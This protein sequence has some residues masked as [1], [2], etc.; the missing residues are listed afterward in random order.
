[1][2][3]VT[4]VIFAL[5]VMVMAVTGCTLSADREIEEG[6]VQ[7]KI[8]ALQD[9]LEEMGYVAID[10]GATFI[11]RGLF[12]VCEGYGFDDVQGVDSSSRYFRSLSIGIKP[13]GSFAVIPSQ[14]KKSSM[15]EPRVVL[16]V[17]YSVNV[18]IPYGGYYDFWTRED[19]DY[20][21]NQKAAVIV[22]D[23]GKNRSVTCWVI[24]SAHVTELGDILAKIREGMYYESFW[25]S[26]YYD[27][28]LTIPPPGYGA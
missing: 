9:E 10:D 6:E 17:R 20:A 13:Y 24:S 12:D 3:K 23:F 11:P 18:K 22:Y 2:K 14:P 8:A 27:P 19:I 25:G 5:V 15:A 21:N 7:A 28:E 1:M 16:K 26:E 4:M